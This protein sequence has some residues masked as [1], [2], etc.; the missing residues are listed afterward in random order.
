MTSLQVEYMGFSLLFN[1]FGM[2]AMM[3]KEVMVGEVSVGFS[4]QCRWEEIGGGRRELAGA[5]G[6]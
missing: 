4:V 1:D 3:G 5:E 6:R 2:V